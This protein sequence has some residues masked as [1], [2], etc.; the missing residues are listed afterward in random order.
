MTAPGIT[1]R[2]RPAQ[3]RRLHLVMRDATMIE[4]SIQI[5]EDQSLVHYFN[6]RRGG[7]MSLTS[8]RRPKLDEPAGHM[9][10]QSD[11]IIMA[12][13]PD[14]N[15]QVMATPSAGTE[16][17]AIEVVLIGGKTLRGFVAAARQQRLSDYVASSGR[18]IGLTRASLMP[19]DRPLGDV[20]LHSGSVVIFRDLRASAPTD[21]GSS[22]QDSAGG[23]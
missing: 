14:A 10:L 22:V 16:E 11:Q 3:S 18:F 17:R 20:A 2:V 19:E 4:G 5:G 9:I 15:I 23:I 8:A 6:S 1:G 21:E 12:S 13:A 7:W